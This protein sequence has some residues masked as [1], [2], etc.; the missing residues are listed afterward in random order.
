MRWPSFNSLVSFFS[1][2][3]L[4]NVV[5]SIY[6]LSQLFVTPACEQGKPCLKSYLT[7]RPEL[8]LYMFISVKE[9]PVNRAK[10]IYLEQNF[11]YSEE[12]TIHTTLS[13]PHETRQNGTLF[14][15]V[16]VTPTSVKHDGSFRALRTNIFTTFTTIKMTQYTVPEAEAF[17]LLEEKDLSEKKT[18]EIM[19]HP[20]VHIKSHVTFT[21][22]TD[23][24]MLPLFNIPAELVQYIKLLGTNTYLP[25]V[26]YDSLR[27]RRRN[28]QRLV[29][30]NS[31]MNVTV[32]YSP[33]SL[34]K[35][36]M[37]L[38]VQASIENVKVLGFSDKDVDDVKGI[39]TETNIYLL[40][41]TLFIASVHLLFDFLAI[42]NDVSF[43]WKK[44]NLVGLSVWTIIWRAFSQ[45]VIFLYLCEEG[46]SLLILIPAGISTVIDLWKLK[47][48]SRVELIRS[49]GILPKIQFKSDCV[50]AAEEK[51][52]KF[53][54]QSM[55]YLSYLLYPLVIVGAI[56]SLF[57][58][59]HK[60]WYSW[61]INSLVNGVYS[62]GFL[63]MLP[64]L[65]INY[66]LK[67]V[68]H[69]PW[70]TIMYKAFNTFI[71]DVFAFIITTPTSHRIAC[72][73]NDIVFVVYLYQRWLYPVDKSRTDTD[74]I[75]E[76][77]DLGSASKKTN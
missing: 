64:Q 53:D 31:T 22:M 30:Q 66:K 72:F 32:E 34:G 39:F 57:Y 2:V 55:R 52:R 13:I 47:K 35:L 16:F 40:S 71:D 61:S 25:I 3:F 73:R 20:V 28:L 23:D 14:L 26:N 56:Y 49:G 1:Y 62:F 41:G 65:F 50:N 8:N 48:V 33:I 54:A 17:K 29:P 58:Q 70:K 15:H 12:R 45:I 46:A 43:W 27:T 11:N 18:K 69:V 6:I 5:Y 7:E 36:R 76:T 60:S 77:V 37:L 21:I 24:I 10:L 63:F 4:I 9:K 75:E 42:K 44:N 19:L 59:P 68:A 51:T 67:S 38:Q 74:T